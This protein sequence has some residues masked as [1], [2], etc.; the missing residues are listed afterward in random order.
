MIHC[1]RYA[2][3]RGCDHAEEATDAVIS[4]PGFGWDVTAMMRINFF[5]EHL[6]LIGK[7][8]ARQTTSSSGVTLVH[9]TSSTTDILYRQYTSQHFL[10]YHLDSV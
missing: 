7:T 2:K 6:R 8:S 10:M 1:V 3:I 4:R 9:F 5:A